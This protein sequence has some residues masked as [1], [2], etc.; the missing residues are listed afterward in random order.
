MKKIFALLLALCL[1]F[2][3]VACGGKKTDDNPATNTNGN[4]D[5]NGK[6]Y[7]GTTLQIWGLVGDQ[8]QNIEKINAKVWHYMLCAAM[9]EW[10]FLNDVKLEYV[11]AYNQ[12]SMVSAIGSGAKPDFC[13][14]TN[15]FP[16]TANVGLIQPFTEAQKDKI[17]AVIGDSWFN[18]YRG[19]ACG[20]LPPWGGICLLYYNET[21]IEN[22]GLKTPRDY[23][24]EDNWTWDTFMELARQCTR[25]IDSDGKL[26]TVGSCLESTKFFVDV[27]NED[28]ETGKLTSNMLSDKNKK[29]AELQYK[30]VTQD[31]SIVTGFRSAKDTKSPK[32]AM[33]M[34]DCEPYNFMHHYV[35]KADGDVIKVAMPPAQTKDTD[36]RLLATNYNMFI[37]AGSDAADAAADMIAYICQAGLKWIADHSMGLYETEFEGIT[38]ACEYS[39]A[40]KELYD[41]FMW[42]RED[43]FALIEDVYDQ[44]Y[45]S[46]LLDECLSLPKARSSNYAN[47][48]TTMYT[49]KE[50]IENPPATAISILNARLENSLNKYNELFLSK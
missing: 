10:A 40:W 24:D 6:P 48:V 3:L 43:E 5:N 38:G 19:E 27:V 16:S 33:T 36:P 26:D 31:K 28:P 11:A 7:A 29:Y 22:Y 23:I 8:Y 30:G 45:Y 17:S 13:F 50:M 44:E 49:Q 42:E 20:V 37:P 2:G 9:E 18:M 34:T 46:N 4:T 41:D 35:E 39:K 47:L 21:M 25:D 12:E 14:T 1:V 32:V 15:Q